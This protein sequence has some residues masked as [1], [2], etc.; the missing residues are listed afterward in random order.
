LKVDIVELRGRKRQAKVGLGEGGDRATKD[1]G[2]PMGIVGLQVE[3][4]KRGFVVVDCQ[5]RGCSEVL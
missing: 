3:R 2:N 4:H 5:A 1:G